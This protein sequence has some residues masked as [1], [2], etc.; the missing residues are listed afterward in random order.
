MK[1]FKQ[2]ISE[3]FKQ[4]KPVTSNPKIYEFVMDRKRL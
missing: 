1:L 3:S 4:F 2:F